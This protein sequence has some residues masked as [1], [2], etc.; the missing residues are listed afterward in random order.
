MSKK[1]IPKAHLNLLEK[2]VVFSNGRIGIVKAINYHRG[3]TIVRRDDPEDML[4]C[5]NRDIHVNPSENYDAATYRRYF[6]AVIRGVKKGEIDFHELRS[7]WH[8][9]LGGVNTNC[10]FS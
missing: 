4:I 6:N 10:A 5:L 9:S 2:E 1:S 8:L 7:I 3:I